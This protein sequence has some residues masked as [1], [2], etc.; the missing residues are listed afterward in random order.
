VLTLHEQTGRHF[1]TFWLDTSGQGQILENKPVKVGDFTG[2][3]F[4]PK[5]SPKAGAT[6][7]HALVAPMC[8]AAIRAAILT[9]RTPLS[10]VPADSWTNTA[11]GVSFAVQS[12]AVRNQLL[13][14]T[15]T[16][17]S[18]F[19]GSIN[20]ADAKKAGDRCTPDS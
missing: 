17:D 15:V 14:V 3:F 20:P 1:K 11:T 9:A 19:P 7:D 4:D 2:A 12:T 10:D 5:F 18:C 8:K 16:R 13:C 6:T